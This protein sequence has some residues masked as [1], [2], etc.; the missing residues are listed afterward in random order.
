MARKKS[1][2]YEAPIHEHP[3]RDRQELEQATEKFLALL[4]AEAERSEQ[5]EPIEQKKGRRKV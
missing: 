1:S 3:E 2:K 4:R 5:S